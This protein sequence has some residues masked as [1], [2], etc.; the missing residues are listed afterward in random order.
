MAYEKYKELEELHTLLI[1]LDRQIDDEDEFELDEKGYREEVCSRLDEIH[2][3]LKEILDADPDLPVSYR[4]V[5]SR[6]KDFARTRFE[7]RELEHFG[8]NEL[9]PLI[10]EVTQLL[11]DT[12]EI[13]KPRLDNLTIPILSLV[14]HQ[15]HPT[16]P[17]YLVYYFKQREHAEYFEEMMKEKGLFYERFDEF[18]NKEHIYWFGVREQDHDAVEIIN[19]TVK[20]KF[21]QPLIKDKGARYVVLGV[22]VL[23]I[24]LAII[25]AII[26]NS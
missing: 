10:K 16:R 5:Q 15:S 25:G 3:L 9:T 12:E 20:G 2:D 4:S 26:S 21:R 14:N 8:V 24:L 1:D 23:A 13:R 6:I 7:Y 18:R 17:G 19:Y 11:E 22:G